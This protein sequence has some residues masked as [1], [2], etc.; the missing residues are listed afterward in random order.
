[1]SIYNT[2]N[3]K[4]WIELQNEFIHKYG[5]ESPSPLCASHIKDDGTL[6]FQ[7]RHVLT[8]ASINYLELD[9]NGRI[10]GT[11]ETED[12]VLKE[13]F[14]TSQIHMSPLFMVNDATD[15]KTEA[16]YFDSLASGIFNETRYI[17]D[18]AQL[19]GFVWTTSP[20]RLTIAK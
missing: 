12:E 13:L 16:S 8:D 15:E 14:N 10:I 5:K 7:H 20:K 4:K 18:Q 19:L 6:Y 9:I 1:M 2:G 3:L 17:I 11:I